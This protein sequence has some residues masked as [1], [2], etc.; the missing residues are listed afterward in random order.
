MSDDLD[1]RRRNRQSDR[2]AR[3]GA[4][5][6]S[7]RDDLP[8]WVT[9]F[10]I[11]KTACDACSRHWHHKCWGVNVLLNPIPDCP[12][13]CGDR[14]DPARLSPQAWADL[15]LH[16]PDQVWVAAMFDRQRAA[17]LHMCETT[18]EGRMHTYKEERVT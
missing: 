18:D 4:T 7:S 6:P 12:C 5:L 16:A 8:G 3:N 14:K 13:D 15:A 2:R 1:A 9:S 17:G 11:P 10:L